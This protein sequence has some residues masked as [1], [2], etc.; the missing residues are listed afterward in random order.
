MAGFKGANLEQAWQIAGQDFWG[1]MK[2]GWKLWPIVSLLNYTAV[3]TVGGRSLVG[4]LAGMGWN[5]YL[6]LVAGR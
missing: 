4:S 5:V 6:S 2:A 1:I 3:R